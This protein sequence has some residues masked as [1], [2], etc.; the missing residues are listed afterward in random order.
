VPGT[1]II[2]SENDHPELKHVNGSAFKSVAIIPDPRYPGYAISEQLTIHFGL[3][4]GLVVTSQ[5]IKGIQVPGLERGT[6]LITYPRETILT[7]NMCTCFC[8]DCSQG[9]RK[10]P[11]LAKWVEPVET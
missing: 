1:P 10:V 9:S 3:P 5:D 8:N 7:F 2:T 6:L 11:L 4:A